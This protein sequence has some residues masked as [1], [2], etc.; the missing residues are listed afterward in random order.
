MKGLLLSLLASVATP[1]GQLNGLSVSAHSSAP[2]AL[3]SNG[4][5]VSEQVSNACTAV[6]EGDVTDVSGGAIK[7]RCTQKSLLG[8]VSDHL[9]ATRLRHRRVTFSAKIKV[10]DAMY[11]SLWLKTQRGTTTLMFDNDVEQSLLTGTPMEDGFVTRTVTLPI[12]AEATHISFGVL[13][14]GMG[15]V[16]L[17][18]VHLNVSQPGKIV[19][20]AAQLLDEVINIV[21]QQTRLRTDLQWRVIEP[22]MRLFASGA[23][24][25]ADTYPAIQY[26]LSVLGD[27]KGFLLTPETTA[28]FASKAATH[29]VASES[30]PTVSFLLPDGARLVL[31]RVLTNGLIQTAQK[32]VPTTA[33]P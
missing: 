1:Q 22:Q 11:A 27:K 5:Q 7:L 13:L 8:N 21:K 26:L 32:L 17:S 20:E 19:P 28:L 18:E 10:G 4:W 6:A 25:T 30:A 2:Q 14:N 29:S 33:L 9:D 12:A 24:T 31:S 16:N 3:I 23:Q 15:D